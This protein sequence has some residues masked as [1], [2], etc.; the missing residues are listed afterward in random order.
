VQD[1]KVWSLRRRFVFFPFAASSQ[2]GNP[3]GST[4]PALAKK[5]K[6]TAGWHEPQRRSQKTHHGQA[7]TGDINAP[8]LEV[9][10][11]VFDIRSWHT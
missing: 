5:N 1:V 10:V 8:H 6:N 4:V 11:D 9:S 2:L 3:A 7:M